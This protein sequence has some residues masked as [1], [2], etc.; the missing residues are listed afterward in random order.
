MHGASLHDGI[1]RW[2]PRDARAYIFFFIPVDE[3]TEGKEEERRISTNEENRG[4]EIQANT[5]R[6]AGT[7]EE[8][9]M[10]RM[11]RHLV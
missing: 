2:K 9:G 3:L 1:P 6:G 11:F 5:N 4:H 7:L 8:A 10:L